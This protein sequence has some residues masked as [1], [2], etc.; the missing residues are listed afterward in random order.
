[1]AGTEQLTTPTSEPTKAEETPA[2]SGGSSAPSSSGAPTRSALRR[3]SYKAASAALDPHSSSA[4]DLA[5][6]GLSGPGQSVGAGDA[7]KFSQATG[8]DV[9]HAKEHTGPAATAACE[10]LGNVQAYSLGGAVAYRDSAPKE[11]VRHHELAHVAQDAGGVQAYG[12][13]NAALEANADAVADAVVSGGKAEVGAGSTGLAFYHG[14]EGEIETGG[15][16]DDI[17]ASTETKKETTEGTDTE[18]AE[19]EKTD[20]IEDPEKTE[21]KKTEKEVVAEAHGQTIDALIEELQEVSAKQS[22]VFKFRKK[23]KTKLA[24]ADAKSIFA[25]LSQYDS[26]TITAAWQVVLDK[27]GGTSGAFNTIVNAIGQKDAARSFPREARATL[28]AADPSALQQLVLDVHTSNAFAAELALGVMEPAARATFVGGNAG[29]AAFAGGGVDTQKLDMADE[30]LRKEEEDFRERS[31]DTKTS[32]EEKTKAAAAASQTDTT[33]A[34]I[35]GIDQKIAA[36]TFHK[37]LVQTCAI[38]DEAVFVAVVRAIDDASLISGLSFDEKWNQSPHLMQRL[39]TARPS[40]DNLLVARKMLDPEKYKRTET[41]T[42]KRGKEKTKKRESINSTEAYAAFQLLKALPATDRELFEKTYPDLVVAMNLHLNESMRTADDTNMLG[43]GG[44][45]KELIAQVVAKIADDALWFDKPPGELGQSI[46]MALTAGRRD[47]VA[48]KLAEFKEAGRLAE[49]MGDGARKSA[50]EG[51]LGLDGDPNVVPEGADAAEHWYTSLKLTQK[52]EDKDEALEATYL[53]KGGALRG[54]VHANKK[55][56]RDSRKERKA[57]REAK[58]NGEEV[59]EKP[60]KKK[61]SLLR[62]AFNKKDGLKA[63]NIALDE[64]QSMADGNAGG[65]EFVFKDYGDR[66][67][68]NKDNEGNRADVLFD[69]NKGVF[70]FESPNMEL[71]RIRYPSGDMLVETGPVQIMGLK[72]SAT[73]PTAQNPSQTSSF[74]V[75]ATSVQVGD[76][77]MTSPG[78]LIGIAS[79]TTGAMDYTSAEEQLDF[80]DNPGADAVLQLLEKYNPARS[81]I[82]Y[83]QVAA[84]GMKKGV[85]ENVVAL[86]EAFSGTVSGA[87]GGMTVNIDNMTASGITYNAGVYVEEASIEGFSLVWDSRPSVT[88]AARKTQLEGMLADAQTRLA[89]VPEG[90]KDAV[91]LE[92][93]ARLTADIAKWQSETEAITTNMPTW[94]KQEKLY[95]EIYEH[96]KLHGSG[97][98]DKATKEAA[99]KAIREQAV[100]AGMA[101]AGSMSLADIATEIQG[102]LTSNSGLVTTIDEVS[103]K[104][105]DANGVKVDEAT[106]SGVT[107]TGSGE[108]I[109]SAVDPK[110][111]KGLGADDGETTK[112]GPDGTE[113]GLHVAEVKTTGV[114]IDGGIP[115][116]EALDKLVKKRSDLKAEI[117]TISAI[118]VAARTDAQKTTLKTCQKN[119]DCFNAQW[120]KVVPGGETYGVVVEEMM[121][122]KAA[123][124]IDRIKTDADL[125]AQ[126]Q[127]LGKKLQGEPTTIE[128]I[129]ALG[130][131]VEGAYKSSDVVDGDVTTNT[132]ES[133]TALSLGSVT[134]KGIKSGD[135]TVGSA[136]VTNVNASA[137]ANIVTETDKEN[138]DDATSTYTGKAGVTVGHVNATD[139]NVA[140][141]DVKEANID[142]VSLDLTANADSTDL[143]LKVGKVSTKGVGKQKGLDVAHAKQTSLKA[144]IAQLREKGEDTAVLE[145]ELASLDASLQGYSDAYATQASV[146]QEIAAIDADI[147]ATRSRLAAAKTEAGVRKHRVSASEETAIQQ[148]DQARVDAIKEE[149]KVLKRIRSHTRKELGAPQ[150]IIASFE[151]TL[152]ISDEAS[153]SNIDLAVSGA[154]SMT[155]LMKEGGDLSGPIN[156]KLSAG[157]IKIPTVNYNGASTLIRLGGASVPSIVADATVTIN[158]ETKPDGKVAHSLGAVDVKTLSIPSM[159]GTNLHLE[160]P[161]G[162]ELVEIDLPK[163]TLGGLLLQGVHLDGFDAASLQ[164]AT[165][166]FDIATLQTSMSVKMGENMSA[167]GSMSLSGLHAEALSSGALNFGFADLSLDDLGFSKTD[168]KENASGNSIVAQIIKMGGK[169]NKLGKISVEGSYDRIGKSLSAT[170]GLGDLVLSGIDYNGG[171]TT[172]GVG[173]ADLKDVSVTVKAQFKQGEVKE[174]ESALESLIIDEFKAKSLYGKAI[175]YKGSGKQRQRFEDGT[176]EVHDVTTAVSLQRGHLHGISVRGLKLIGEGP[177]AFGMSLGSASVTGLKTAMTKDGKSLLQSNVTASVTGV[178]VSLLDDELK[179]KVK[180]IDG[181]VAA[182]IGSGDSAMNIDL[183]NVHATDTDVAVHKMGSEDQSLDASVGKMTASGLAFEQ[184][185]KGSGYNKPTALGDVTLNGVTIHDD[186]DKMSVDVDSGFGEMKG[187]LDVTGTSSGSTTEQKALATDDQMFVP[188]H[189]VTW[190]NLAKSSLDGHLKVKYPDGSQFAKLN[191]TGD[192]VALDLQE[193][194]DRMW[195]E[196]ADGF[197]NDGEGAFEYLWNATKSILNTPSALLWTAIYKGLESGLTA[198]GQACLGD[199]PAIE[200]TI[201][202]SLNQDSKTSVVKGYSPAEGP[203]VFTSFTDQ[204]NAVIQEKVEPAIEF[205]CDTGIIYDMVQGDWGGAAASTGSYVLEQAGNLADWGASWFG[206]DNVTDVDDE[207]EEE[208]AKMRAQRREEVESMIKSGIGKIFGWGADVSLHS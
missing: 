196:W 113:F 156:I 25:R 206:Y 168:S 146:Q 49:L 167:K 27:Q 45:D 86:T 147:D 154:P 83:G 183:E 77:M 179:A 7:G 133:S 101:N 121:T 32:E 72:M 192:G 129:T 15:N 65:G 1:M 39:F 171:S 180:G 4:L 14:N 23:K 131:S 125:L 79:L 35:V 21:P 53:G 73:W 20:A 60:E 64:M 43:A 105:V 76:I 57:W 184:G 88:G 85:D 200:K 87:M 107:M 152:G 62:Q 175:H 157:P 55:T 41:T 141:V 149:L 173:Y 202:E 75:E 187:S 137:D 81:I 195:S 18:K 172:L 29:L 119:L 36:G 150:A 148:A 165:G 19:P 106:I 151:S 42:N 34:L 99:E 170:V 22:K 112:K 30:S 194:I 31:E 104:G 123:E 82:G 135:T 6:G 204:I 177:A 10:A 11:H 37:A 28:A 191:F 97:S 166:E 44:G 84:K 138:P 9:S 197:K 100:T 140:G 48:G 186:K 181:S 5:Q 120:T 95:Q 182:T 102:V 139:M 50:I 164:T 78:T 108:S 89:A 33:K 90:S 162:G 24:V 158:K 198:V 160:M 71:E 174:G 128:S 26:Q 114:T 56:R 130:L 110:L 111:L 136:T 116:D 143:H 98:P 8:I 74:H 205:I 124:G 16:P 134:A 3:L 117:A 155:E 2:S 52:I 185:I 68:D 91:S 190:T 109:G 201:L 63:D 59:G 92:S 142:D 47:A 193:N 69:T 103:A 208:R 203:A 12:G 61:Q 67:K 159:E 93:R 17:A 38:K 80:S 51:A 163:A 161:I 169:A 40:A 188:S 144:Q 145:G 132:V 207:M 126:W 46:K 153:I 199:W 115:S 176:E 127:A 122:L 13:G 96:Q 118:E 70:E 54:I 94:K 58:K 189:T 178:S 66:S